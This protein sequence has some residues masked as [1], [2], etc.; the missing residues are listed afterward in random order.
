[1][2]RLWDYA[3]SANDTFDKVRPDGLRLSA[4]AYTVVTY[5]VAAWPAALEPREPTK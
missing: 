2:T 1:M 5:M 3:H 4:A